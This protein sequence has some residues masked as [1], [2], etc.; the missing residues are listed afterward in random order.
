MDGAVTIEAHAAR[1]SEDWI[2]TES[3]VAW[4]RTAFGE[5]ELYSA[6]FHRTCDELL[7]VAVVG[8][9]DVAPV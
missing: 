2:A 8:K 4:F 6:Q 5:T 3:G 1:W 7:F 9:L